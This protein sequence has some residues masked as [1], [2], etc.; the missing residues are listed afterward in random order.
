[1]EPELDAMGYDTKDPYAPAAKFVD[2]RRRER[3]AELRE[4]QRLEH[5][6]DKIEDS[7]E[8]IKKWLRTFKVCVA[9]GFV[10]A[11]GMANGLFSGEADIFS[12][13]IKEEFFSVRHLTAT[14]QEIW[15]YVAI[16]AAF[17]VL[18]TYNNKMD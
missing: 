15:I 13:N 12:S 14:I 18:R 3:A 4:A 5:M 8:P 17:M 11:G 7:K 1:M 9:M 2:K 10:I 6:A 16:F